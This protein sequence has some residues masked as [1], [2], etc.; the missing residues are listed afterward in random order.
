MQVQRHTR[1]DKNEWAEGPADKTVVP[2]TGW[3]GIKW[4]PVGVLHLPSLSIHLQVLTQ[5]NF[6]FLGIFSQALEYL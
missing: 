2:S 5:L 4:L 3:Y 1:E 6:L